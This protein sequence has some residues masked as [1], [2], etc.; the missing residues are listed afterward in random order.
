MSPSS[1]SKPS[2]LRR[3]F[4][5]FWSFLDSSRRVLVN[6][7]LLAIIIL[8]VVSKLRIAGPKLDDK[9]VLV[10][11]LSGPLVE[12]LAGSPGN[13]I[14]RQLRGGEIKQAQLRDV[15]AVLD[16]A[17]KDPKID[18]M[19]L[20]LDEFAP[21]GLASLHE[22]ASAIDR[23]KASGKQVLA[24]GSGYDQ[25]QYYLA[26]HANE[27]YMHPMG[28]LYIDGFGGY[29]NYY[30]DALDRLGI[31][32]NVIRVGTY[33][34]YGENYSSNAPSKESMEAESYLYNGLWAGYT[35]DVEAARK[36]PAGSI[37][38]GIEELPQKFA[39][40]GNDPAKLALKNK[41]VDGLKTRDEMRQM[42]IE[43]GARDE[44]SKSFRQ[45]SFENYLTGV[46]PELI[47]DAIGVVVAEGEI[48]EGIEPAGKIGGRS[49]AELIR[50]ARE[51]SKIKAVVLRV[52]SPGGS[53]FGSELIRRELEVT[54]LAG[55]PVV[56]SM[57][58]VAASGG[59]WI[60]MSSDEVIADPQTVTGSIGVVAILPTA[61][62]AM[63]KLSIN[64]GGYTTTWLRGAY[65]PRRPMDPHFRQLI[66]GSIETVYSEFT[67]RAAAA[68]K[69]TQDKIDAVGQGRVWTGAQAKER[70]LVD[71]LGSFGD[72]LQSAATRAR[73][74]GN[75]RVI[76]VEADVSPFVRLLSRIGLD[77][78]AALMQQ[79]TASLAKS[80]AS[81]F[82][83]AGLPDAATGGMQRDMAWLAG[84]AEKTHNGVPFV[85][86][87]HCLCGR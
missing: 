85:A 24:W 59:Y 41:M 28:T 4:G 5:G 34:N 33:K 27:V 2:F 15:L 39:E 16:T 47:G 80:V 66:Q 56:V 40:A 26:S 64:T 53:A 30:K 3:T 61:D 55:K 63:E 68:R 21:N 10:L 60:T 52:N 37:A 50:K 29:R 18:R 19:L 75:A 69:T 81:Y 84:I 73:I 7:I 87:T 74:D 9:T 78:S 51:D 82:L 45:V 13:L 79:I 86:L 22:V 46:H 83:P 1:P 76:Y 42:L 71:R 43:R 20:V 31:T 57:G 77:A 38:K 25:R 49:T 36:L 54:R 44:D 62:K 8:I 58:D 65:D 11:D 72:A 48:S 35:A 70:N 32:A 23:F 67:T 12:Q 14:S 17:A 6:L